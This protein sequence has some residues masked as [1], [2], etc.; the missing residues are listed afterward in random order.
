M[1]REF[2]TPDADAPG[3]A[4]R[5]IVRISRIRLQQRDRARMAMTAA[6]GACF[7]FGCVLTYTKGLQALDEILSSRRK[8]VLTPVASAPSAGRD[9]RQIPITPDTTPVASIQPP[10]AELSSPPYGP[11]AFPRVE[12]AATY[13]GFQV[14]AGAR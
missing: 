6:L 7:A 10:P 8:P 13:S 1:S 2:E 9:V 14:T 3:A 12:R 11:R 5:D 4:A